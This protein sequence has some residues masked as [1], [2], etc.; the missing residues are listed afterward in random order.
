MKKALLALY[1]LTVSSPA[2]AGTAGSGP[3]INVLV[4]QGGPMLFDLPNNRSGAPACATQA[5]RFAI[6][7]NTD[8][9]KAMISII[10]SAQ[11][12]GKQV[13][14]NGTGNCSTWGDSEGVDYVMISN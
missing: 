3:P 7:S 5:T 10:L 2:L 8:W 4:T 9:G 13:F 1:A 11:A 12:A 6:P 14:I